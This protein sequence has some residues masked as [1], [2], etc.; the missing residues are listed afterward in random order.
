[1]KLQCSFPLLSM[2]QESKQYF[3][4]LHRGG[5]REELLEQ[6]DPPLQQG[7]LD[8]V[9]VQQF[10]CCDNTVAFETDTPLLFCPLLLSKMHVFRFEE[11][12]VLYCF[13]F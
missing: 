1:M 5:P 3:V 13:Y 6:N 2:R 12:A 4:Q 11:L 7:W 9:S 8:M 10:R